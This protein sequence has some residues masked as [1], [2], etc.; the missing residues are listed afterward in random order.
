M[1]FRKINSNSE[2]AFVCAVQYSVVHDHSDG[3]W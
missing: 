2:D 3:L 1:L